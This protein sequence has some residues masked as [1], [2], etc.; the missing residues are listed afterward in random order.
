MVE[1]SVIAEVDEQLRGARVWACICVC[2]CVCMY[3][4]LCIY[5]YVARNK[6]TVEVDEQLHDASIVR[7]YARM[8]SC[9][10]M[11]I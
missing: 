6:V 9:I 4:Y 11:Y 1:L 7:M 10:C 5:V 8:R 3:I 2:V